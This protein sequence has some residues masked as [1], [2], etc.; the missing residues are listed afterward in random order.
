[1]SILVASYDGVMQFNAETKA[2]QHFYAKQ[3]ASWQEI[4]FSNL[5]HGDLTRAKQAFEV[6]AAYGRLTLQKVRGL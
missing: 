6:A 1:M 4:A 2:P 5:K 3:L